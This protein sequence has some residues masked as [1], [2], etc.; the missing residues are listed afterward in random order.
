MPPVIDKILR[1]GEGKTL[2]KLKKLADQVNSIEEDFL[3]MSDAELRELTDKYRERLADG[4][5]LDDLLPEAF[6]TA[7]EAAKRVLGQRHYDVQVMGGAALHL[8]NIAEMK[9][10]EGKTLTCVLPAYLNALAGEG[11]HVVTV[12]DYLA[13]RDAEW[14]GRV[15]QFLGLDVGVILPQMTPDE[16]RAA[17]GCDITYGTNNEFGF[18]YLRDNMAW[19]LEECVQRGHHYAIVDE[20]DS[21]LIDEAR[22]PL[23]I[24]GPAEQ[25]SKWYS[26]F[27]KIVP[28]LKRAELIST[29]GQVDEYGP[30]DYEV[31][32]KKRTVGITESGVEKVEDW[33]GIDNLYD[34][35]NTPLVSFLNNALKAKELYKRDK[36]YVVMNGEVLIVDEFTGRILHGRRYN[37][38]MHQAIEAKEG[39]SIKDENQTLATITLQNF[40]RLYGKLSGMTGTAET[41]A[42]EFNKTYKIGVVPIPTNEPMIRQD[43]PDVVYKTEQ[44]KFEAVVDDIAERHDKGQPVLVGTTSVEKSEKLHKMLKRRGIPHQVLNAKHHEQESTIVAEAGRKGGVT[45]ATNMAGR[46]TDIMLGGN[47]DFRADLELHQRGLS[48]LET[49]EEY[50]A[51]WP[52]ALEKA[53]KDVGGEHEEVVEVGGLY[54]LATERHESRRIDNQ[55]RG[56]SGRQG[57]PGESKFYLSLEDDLMRLFNSARVESIMNRLNIPDEQPIESKIVTNAIKSAQSQVEQQNF[58]MRKNVLKYDEVLNRQRK[59]IYAE[60]RK[61]LE[62]EDLGEQVRNMIDEVVAGY[63]AGATSEGFAEDWDLDRLWKAFKQLYQIELTVDDLVEEVGGDISGLDAETLAEKIREDAHRA[64]QAREDELTAD[65]MRELERR[66]VLNVLDRKWREHLYEMDYLQEGI[67]LRAMAQRDPLV[68]YQREGYDMFNAMLDGIKEESVGY[69]FSLEVQTDEEEDA[70]TVGAAPVSVAKS[71]PAKDGAA[72]DGA[73]EADDVVEADDAPAIKA[74]GLDAPKRPTKLEYSAPTVDGDG[75][76]EH[77]SEETEDEYAGVNRN[78][79]CPCGSGKKFKR[80]HGDPRNKNK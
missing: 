44:A 17:Y 62:G 68:E 18:D 32:E 56:R 7:R 39:V 35:V 55:L 36:D 47:P 48:P 73:D 6:A 67:G 11:V 25:N 19:T 49:P 12:N 59:V 38:G 46:G 61:V 30:G 27:A 40:F 16:R 57:D 65:V 4:E 13:K 9:T 76:V 69:L 58:E 74:K 77:H 80:C 63:V 15:H 37:E 79:P 20:V 26:E 60:R 14:M 33:L 78:D 66:V 22:T 50:E 45:V 64:Y 52:E 24:S 43:V 21:I 72:E 5:S 51:A 2:R 10:G 70:P 23:I 29:A 42:A 71:A 41:E 31:N 3:E 53:K 54:V 28:R 75:G 8:G 1:A 34:S